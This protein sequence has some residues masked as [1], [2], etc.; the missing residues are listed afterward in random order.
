M[1]D[2]SWKSSYDKQIEL[3]LGLNKQP[4]YHTHV[5]QAVLEFKR[6]VMNGGEQTRLTV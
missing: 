2:I 3:R 1:K 6:G 5:R 4:Y